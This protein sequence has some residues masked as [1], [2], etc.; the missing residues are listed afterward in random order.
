M[1]AIAAHPDFD[2]AHHKPPARRNGA[3]KEQ[4][5]LDSWA[6]LE[7]QRGLAAIRVGRKLLGR[8]TARAELVDCAKTV[9]VRFTSLPTYPSVQSS[10]TARKLRWRTPKPYA[11]ASRR[12]SDPPVSSGVLSRAAHV[13][14]W[15]NKATAAR[16]GL[17]GHPHLLRALD[18]LSDKQRRQSLTDMYLGGHATYPNFLDD[19]RARPPPRMPC[20]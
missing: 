11:W 1:F 19:F 5:S 16:R 17:L 12:G 4:K 8:G 10:P 6:P 9:L 14:V 7:V 3:A 13:Q 18:C 20:V 2:D 15:A